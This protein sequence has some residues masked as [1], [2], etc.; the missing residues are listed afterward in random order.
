MDWAF[1]RERYWGT[2]L[3]LWRCSGCGEYK[4]I[5]SL[6]ELRSQPGLEGLVEPLDLHRPYVDRIT[7]TCEHCSGRLQRTPEVLDAWFDSGAMPVAQWH[8]PFENK[9]KFHQ[10][11]PADFICEGVDQ[12]RGWFYTLH[13]LATMLF[14]SPCYKNVICLGLV[15][16]AKGEKMSKRRGNVVQPSAVLQKYGADALRWYLYTSSPA[17]NVRLFSTD[18]LAQSSRF[19]VTLWNIYSFFIT[20]AN[21][22]G[23]DPSRSIE[24]SSQSELDRWVISELNSLISDVTNGLESYDPTTAARRIEGFVD[25]LSNWY[26]RR[27]R[28]RFW[29]SENDTDKQAAYYT[30]VSL[31]GYRVPANGSLRP[32]YI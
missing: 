14:D 21:I 31:P 15:L 29:K 2:P 1:S 12:T 28:R 3:N 20:Y 16:D 22:D 10:S 11:F 9:E 32:I 25:D 18:Q 13:A 26:V 8:Y 17:G 7:F 27:S 23:Y 6:A 30:L 4:F 24:P 19:F 5:G